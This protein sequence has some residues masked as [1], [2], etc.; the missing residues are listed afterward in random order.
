MRSEAAG[1]VRHEPRASVASSGEA[2]ERMQRD[3]RRLGG[4]ASAAHRTPRALALPRGS[5]AH[6]RP[7]HARTGGPPR[8]ATKQAR[9]VG[10]P[11][12]AA[13][14]SASPAA[15]QQRGAPHI[16]RA[17]QVVHLVLQDARLPA[18]GLQLEWPAV[19]SQPLHL[20][21]SVALH[22]RLH[23]GVCVCVWW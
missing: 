8:G 2:G 12:A 11:V 17:P 5:H 20:H 18:V 9:G 10:L 6:A 21:G 16:Q 3:A 14:G 4:A 23:A 13:R 7:P 22:K 19:H 15:S 1:R